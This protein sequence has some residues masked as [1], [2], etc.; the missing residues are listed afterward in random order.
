MSDLKVGDRLWYVPTMRDGNPKFVRVSKVGTKWAHIVDD[1]DPRWDQGRIHAKDLWLDC[2]GYSSR[3]QCY[4]SKEAYEDQ[5][6]VFEA[7]RNLVSSLQYKS[8]PNG[9]TVED[10]NY[11]RTVLKLVSE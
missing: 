1:A 3:A 7:W 8:A 10:I 6:A 4:V 9:V 5:M 11:A 2:G